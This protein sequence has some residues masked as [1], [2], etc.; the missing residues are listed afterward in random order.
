MSGEDE[1]DYDD[2][3]HYTGT[4]FPKAEVPWYLA[5]TKHGEPDPE[6][7]PGAFGSVGRPRKFPDPDTL[8]AACVEYMEWNE[9]NPLYEVVAYSTKNGV[10]KTTVPRVRAMTMSAL[11]MFLDIDHVT[12]RVY[13][14]RPEFASVCTR[15]EEAVRQQ[16]FQ[17]AAA[18]FL[19]ASI[20]ARDLGLADKKELTGAGGK[21]VEV[22]HNMSPKEAAEAY[23]QSLREDEQ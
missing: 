23:E 18:G 19:N 8:L 6:A 15:V 5:R 3:E 16:K 17:G 12:W 2:S 13:A 7:K 9:A 14:K 22:N 10:V 11:C 1:E 4:G 20:I 21:P